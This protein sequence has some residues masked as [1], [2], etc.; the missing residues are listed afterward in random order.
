MNCVT[1][2]GLQV[3]LRRGPQRVTQP[4]GAAEEHHGARLVQGGQ[5]ERDV[6][7]QGADA[8]RRDVVPPDPRRDTM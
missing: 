5:V 6:Q 7:Q 2:A 1:D 4:D 3:Q 8:E